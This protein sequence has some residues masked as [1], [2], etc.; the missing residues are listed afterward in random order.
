MGVSL[1]HVKMEVITDQSQAGEGFAAFS[2]QY[3]QATDSKS[4]ERV[5]RGIA[6]R[7]ITAKRLIRTTKDIENGEIYIDLKDTEAWLASAYYDEERQSRKRGVN[8][9]SS[10]AL[11]AAD[12]DAQIERAID[13]MDRI[14]RA[15]ELIATNPTTAAQTPS[16]LYL[17]ASTNGDE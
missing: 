15:L 11:P 10:C 4:R 3:P 16:G 1:K 13:L 5:K 7:R 8:R 12:F 17:H 6:E 2:D 9:K 14:A